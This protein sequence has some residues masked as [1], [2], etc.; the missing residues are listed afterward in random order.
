MCISVSIECIQAWIPSASG[1]YVH[2][3]VSPP[4][5]HA[6]LSVAFVGAFVSSDPYSALC[7]WQEA[8]TPFPPPPRHNEENGV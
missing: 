3:I 2:E 5:P 6:I 8:G 7:P 1:V 4:P